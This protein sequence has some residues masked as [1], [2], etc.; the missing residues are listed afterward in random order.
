M[1]IA[2]S[3]PSYLTETALHDIIA[4]AYREDLQT[5]DVTTLATIPLS[6]QAKARFLAKDSG[7]LSGCTVAEYVFHSLDET[8]AIEWKKQDGDRVEKGD[9][10]GEMQ[11]PAHAILSAERIALNLM[12]R[13]SGI[14][15]ATRRMVDAVASHR[16]KILDTRKTAP[17]L[18][19]LDKWAVLA[20]GGQNHRIGLFD[21]I[22]IKDNHIAAAGGIRQAIEAAQTYRSLHA[23]PL[24]IE[25]ETRTLDE[26]DEV[27]AV[28]G[29]DVIMLDNMTTLDANGTLDTSML[30][31]AVRRIDGRYETEAS[32]NVTQATVAAIAATGVDAIS[33]G[34]LTHSVKALDISL[35]VE[36]RR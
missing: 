17:G 21:M 13:M 19:L 22:M 11:G 6:T 2:P 3:F 12:Q 14:A 18:R 30:E 28:G 33:S 23:Q 5:G 34:A 16:T 1:N 26:V 20:G 7:I 29:I 4:G 27:L 36:L 31:R 8:V 10:F 15:T 24:R 35:K 25:V 9:V 32:G